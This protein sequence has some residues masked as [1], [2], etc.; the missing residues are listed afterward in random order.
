MKV[1]DLLKEFVK[2]IPFGLETYCSTSVTGEPYITFGWA[3]IR[4]T[5]DE[6]KP[7]EAYE[8]IVCRAFF[9]NIL[10]YIND[11]K[12]PD[13]KLYWRRKPDLSYD[14]H[15]PKYED[16]PKIEKVIC[17]VTCRV[18][19]SNKPE[20]SERVRYAPFHPDDFKE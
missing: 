11:N 15:I 17:K 10:K 18:L 3:Y 7:M 8:D 16:N 2:V 4:G 1:D 12:K 6:L 5:E 14:N 13:S 19:V 9:E 20:I